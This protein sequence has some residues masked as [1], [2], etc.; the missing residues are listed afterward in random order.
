MFQPIS[1]ASGSGYLRHPLKV[2]RFALRVL[3]AVNQVC[4]GSLASQWLLRNLGSVT[5]AAVGVGSGAPRA[6]SMSIRRLWFL[7]G[8]SQLQVSS[9]IN[10]PQ[11]QSNLKRNFIGLGRPVPND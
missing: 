5:L 9:R 4:V 2:C 3:A 10:S 1:R 8:G 11:S 7:H 6:A